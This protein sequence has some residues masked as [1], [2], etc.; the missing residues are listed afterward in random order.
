MV[1][2]IIEFMKFISEISWFYFNINV[3]QLYKQVHHLF[4]N[5]DVFLFQITN[6]ILF[7]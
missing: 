4:I 2:F 3:T 1:D 7:L 6:W 5:Q